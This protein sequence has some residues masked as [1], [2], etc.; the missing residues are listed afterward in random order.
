MTKSL[1]H[2]LLRS[3]LITISLT[4]L[5]PSALATS[6]KESQDL[7]AVAATQAFDAGDLPKATQLY[8]QLVGQGIVNGHLFYNLGVS[9]YKTGRLGDS[10]AAFLGARRYLPRDPDNQAN[11]HFVMSK[12]QDKLEAQIP[13]GTSGHV[14]TGLAVFSQ[15]ELAWMAALLAAIWGAAFTIVSAKPSLNRW[16]LKIGLAV[17]LPILG[18]AAFL[19]KQATP[20]AWAAINSP[21]AKVYSGPGS[22]NTQ[23]FAL[24]EGSPVLITERAAGGYFRVKLSDGKQGWIADNQVILFGPL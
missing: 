14:A 3:A 9:Y 6:P 23:L 16:Q 5:V 22:H 12:I 13:A 24:H 1:K 19:T 11:L 2:F 15:L 8:E 17:I 7:V 10:V 20:D 4:G 18:L 21:E